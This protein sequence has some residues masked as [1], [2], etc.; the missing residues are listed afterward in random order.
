MLEGIYP[1]LNGIGIDNSFLNLS[2]RIEIQ[3]LTQ[4]R[5]SRMIDRQID[6]A[7]FN[8]QKD[9]FPPTIDVKL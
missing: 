3:L 9:I 6:R 2:A 8:P 7:A 4:G 5:K 1:G